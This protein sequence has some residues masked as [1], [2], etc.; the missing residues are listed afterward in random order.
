[1]T[2]P[3]LQGRVALV[4]GAGRRTGRSIALAL[5]GAGADVLVHCHHSQAEAQ[6]VVQEIACLGRRAKVVQADLGDAE[7]TQAAFS[8][9]AADFGRLDI[10]VNNAC[11]IIWKRLP[12]LSVA[13][14]HAG[15]EQSLHITYHACRAVLPLMRQQG[16]GRIVSVIDVDAD[17]LV[18]VPALTPYKIGKTGVLM[19]TRTLAVTE[20]PHGIT[21]NGVSPGTLDNSD[22]KPA[23]ERIPAGRY[24]TA[25][26][27]ARAVLF[28]VDPESAYITGTNIKVS[29][30]YL[31]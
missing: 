16:F 29:G 20:A 31:I 22:R 15:L 5:A 11:G 6:Q 17:S 13:E 19:L 2:T 25:E 23:L 12:D 14:W 27:V 28:L 26:E 10:L 24:G 9:A 7:A 21:V 30:G 18:S 8:Q 3:S 1:M 4:T